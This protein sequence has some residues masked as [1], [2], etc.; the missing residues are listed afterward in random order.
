MC[1]PQEECVS[2]RFRGTHRQAGEYYGRLMGWL[3]ERGYSVAGFSKEITMIDEGLTRDSS[4]FVTEIQI[5]VEKK[6]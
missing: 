2:V 3:R 6:F 5:P 4:K 1:L